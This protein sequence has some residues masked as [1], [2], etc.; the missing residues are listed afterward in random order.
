MVTDTKPTRHD[1][2]FGKKMAALRAERGGWKAGRRK[3]IER[4]SG[5]AAAVEAVFSKAMKRLAQDYIDNLAV[6]EPE[7]CPRHQAILVCPDESCHYESH[8]TVFKHAMAQ[9]VFDRIM[10]RPTS[11]SEVAITV[12]LVEQITTAVTMAFGEVN[13]IPD[14]DDRRAAFAA[15]CRELGAHFGG[16][17]LGTGGGWLEAEPA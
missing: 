6:I 15:R 1:P 7:E 2:D 11:R 10:G 14:A 13:G 4:H 5:D 17:G 9:Y 8:R 12:R 16:D 3:L